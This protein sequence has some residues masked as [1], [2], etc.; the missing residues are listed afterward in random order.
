M[1]APQ[2]AGQDRPDPGLGSGPGR[3]TSPPPSLMR[4]D[5]GAQVGR[6]SLPRSPDWLGQ[7]QLPTATR[8]ALHE[9]RITAVNPHNETN[10]DGIISPILQ[11]RKLRPR[12]V[13]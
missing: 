2:A 3:H 13:D 5:T 9:A 10:A 6:G 8:Q 1:R 7:S 11:R 4:E 12:K